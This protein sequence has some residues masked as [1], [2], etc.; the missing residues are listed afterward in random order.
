MS[1]IHSNTQKLVY[2]REMPEQ[3]KFYSFIMQLNVLMID[4]D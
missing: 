3:K 2:Y 4:E 1:N